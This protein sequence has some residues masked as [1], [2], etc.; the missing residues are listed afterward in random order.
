MTALKSF[1][2]IN[3]STFK[4]SYE[5]YNRA[6]SIGLKDKFKPLMS[7][8]NW[9]D[10]CK[11]NIGKDMDLGE[12][13]YGFDSK[14]GLIT[15][16]SSKIKIAY[17][18]TDILEGFNDG[19][20]MD[21]ILILYGKP[22]F[23]SILHTYD[24]TK[25]VLY[26]QPELTREEIEEGCVRPEH[27][28][29]SIAV[30]HSIRGSMHAGSDAEKYKCSKYGHWY[31]RIMI[32]AKGEKSRTHLM[33]P[34]NGIVEEVLDEKA[35]SEFTYPITIQPM[36]DTFGYTSIGA[37]STNSYN[38]A[39]MLGQIGT[40]ASAGTG[41]K[42]SFYTKHS[43]TNYHVKFGIYDH[44]DTTSYPVTNGGGDTIEVTSDT[45]QWWD[46][47]LSSSPS[48]SAQDYMIVW[49]AEDNDIYRYYDTGAPAGNTHTRQ[50][51]SY[52]SFPYASITWSTTGGTSFY[53]IYCTYT[54]SGGGT[55]YPIFHS[56]GS[57]LRVGIGSGIG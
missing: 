32:G 7:T 15:A 25:L 54:P 18:A 40:P 56:I 42:I 5:K 26:H 33:P 46:S 1:E 10:E 11:L 27:V 13:E 57:G 34:K 22:S 35:L 38:N 52:S 39:Y 9:D 41:T 51:S 19:G 14:T 28:K 3:N 49:I 55:V 2:A 20:G 12:F 17:K 37:T 23:K 24:V 43:G 4:Q 29:N 6:I 53:S 16:L 30:Y 48:L 36:G 47:N 45:A 50:S 21:E 31:P 8:S 44:S